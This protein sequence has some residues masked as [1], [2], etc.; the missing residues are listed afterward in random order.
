[1]RMNNESQ[2]NS[3]KSKDAQRWLILA[4]LATLTSGILFALGERGTLLEGLSNYPNPFDSRRENTAIVYQLP[5]DTP[6]HVRIYD[7]FGFQVREYAFAAGEMGGRSG[8][9]T[10]A[11]DG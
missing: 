7:L 8:Q 9:N 10:I 11:W 1:N 6:V 5:E 4:A 3:R 2:E